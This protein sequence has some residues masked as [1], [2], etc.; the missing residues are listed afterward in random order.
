MALHGKD[1]ELAVKSHVRIADR[2]EYRI[3]KFHEEIMPI[4]R[5]TAL[6]G[7]AAAS[8]FSEFSFAESPKVA[9]RRNSRQRVCCRQ[10]TLDLSRLEELRVMFKEFQENQPKKREMIAAFVAAHMD[11]LWQGSTPTDDPFA[12]ADNVQ[13]FVGSLPS[14][15]QGALGIGLAW[16]NLRSKYYTQRFF[17]ELSIPERRKI[18][19]QGEEPEGPIG[20]SNTLI[21]LIKWDNRFVA[22]TIVESLAQVTRLVVNSR[23]PARLHLGTNW[24]EEAKKVSN[25]ADD[26]ILNKPEYPQWDDDHD[27]FDVV[28]IGS[29]AGGAVV[30]SEVIKA[31]Y[32][33]LIIEDGDWIHPAQFVQRGIE[34]G[35]EVAYAPKAEESL[36]NTY[37]RSGLNPV[38]KPLSLVKTKVMLEEL[39]RLLPSKEELGEFVGELGDEFGQALTGK[40]KDDEYTVPQLL[41]AIGVGAGELINLVQANVVGLSL[42]HI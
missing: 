34:N 8:A 39:A 33:C 22:H 10:E 28:V 14:G 3:S 41:E 21:P 9:A 40:K 26:P 20:N 1:R 30:A 15:L 16:I 4:N 19:N 37:M 27:V 11:S 38:G 25:L 24:G 18:L 2:D 6:G 35:Q 23:V 31:G 5:R 42:I 13:E 32:S 12:V 29:G 17:T 36:R 7:I